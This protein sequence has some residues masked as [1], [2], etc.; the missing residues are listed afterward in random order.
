MTWN[1]CCLFF[2]LK[3]AVLLLKFSKYSVLI[4]AFNLFSTKRREILW[5][6][7]FTMINAWTCKVKSKSKQK[8][9]K[10]EMKQDTGSI[11]CDAHVYLAYWSIIHRL[12]SPLTLPIPAES[13]LWSHLFPISIPADC[14]QRGFIKIHSDGL[15]SAFKSR[16]ESKRVCLSVQAL[17]SGK[18]ERLCYSTVSSR[19]CKQ[20]DIANR[21]R[22]RRGGFIPWA[23]LCKQ[24][25]CFFIQYGSVI[26]YSPENYPTSSEAEAWHVTMH[27]L[28]TQLFRL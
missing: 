15:K 14:V 24:A 17:I 2:A 25:F 11:R 10:M 3:A 6:R 26:V 7:C 23:L 22:R 19:V 13:P 5:Y 9:V 4:F 8:K 16:R 21:K 27:Y 20:Y 1:K 12:Y 18:E 28:E